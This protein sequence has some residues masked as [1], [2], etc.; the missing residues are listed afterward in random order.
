MVMSM[1][2][3]VNENTNHVNSLESE[4]ELQTYKRQPVVIEHP[5]AGPDPV[6]KGLPIASRIDRRLT[7]Y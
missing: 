3:E 6:P 2:T 4:Y 1:S 7:P 5:S